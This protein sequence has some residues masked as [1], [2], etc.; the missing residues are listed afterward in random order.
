MRR[1]RRKG[2]T[3]AFILL[4]PKWTRIK[5][6]DKIK[7]RKNDTI[8]ISANAQLLDSN[9]PKALAKTSFLSQVVNAE[10]KLSDSGSV[11]ESKGEFELDKE[12]ELFS[13][14]LALDAN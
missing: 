3:S 13:E 2:K 11:A 4:T 9:R 5:D 1:A 10:D 6:P 8:S 14:I 7:K 12:A